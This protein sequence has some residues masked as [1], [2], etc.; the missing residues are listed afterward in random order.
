MLY[1]K[2]EP[3]CLP[4]TN[5]FIHNLISRIKHNQKGGIW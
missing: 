4:T 5:I 3:S 2:V 1:V